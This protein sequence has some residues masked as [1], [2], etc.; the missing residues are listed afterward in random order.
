MWTTRTAAS[1]N[2][3]RSFGSRRGI[4]APR[5]AR[6]SRHTRVG[7]RYRRRHPRRIARA[8]VAMRF[9]VVCGQARGRRRPPARHCGRIARS[10]RSTALMTKDASGRHDA[11]RRAARRTFTTSRRTKANVGPL[12]R[13]YR[14]GTGEDMSGGASGTGVYGADSTSL[15]VVAT[16]TQYANSAIRAVAVSDTARAWMRD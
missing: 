2:W 12:R 13:H 5:P 7:D 8:P 14:R 9:L 11:L 1:P 10:S 3:N 16:R 15:R 6:D 4:H